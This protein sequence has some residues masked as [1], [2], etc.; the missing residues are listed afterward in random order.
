MFNGN[1]H[2]IKE[3]LELDHVTEVMINA[4]NQ[5]FIEHDGYLVQS[6]Q[7]FQSAQHYNEFIQ[8]VLKSYHSDNSGKL[9]YD[10][11]TPDGNRYNLVLPPV[12]ARGPILT[13]RRHSKAV[14]SMDQLVDVGFLSE[15][16]ALFLK[17]ALEARLNIVVCG[18]TS[19]GKTSFLNSLAL[20]IPHDQRVVSIEDT[21]E[22]KTNHPNW[23]HLLT[24]DRPELKYSARD[25]LKNTLRMR[26]DR[27]VVGE[28]RGPEA[29]DMLQAMNTG[30][31]GS[32][33]TLHASSP[34]EGLFRLE[35][36]ISLG[37]PE[38]PIA[39]IRSQ[40]A[41]AI[42]L[43]IQLKRN[44]NGQ[45]YVSDIIEITGKEQDVIT[46]AAVFT[47]NPNTQKLNVVGYVP[48]CLKKINRNGIIIPNQMFDTQT[49]I[50]KSS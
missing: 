9:N 14:Y 29:Y 13:I 7:H 48:N 39:F 4:W 12:A 43:V 24:V 41:A 27:I 26:P 15:K 21:L 10:G 18:G 23:V 49:V 11:V 42:S 5:V 22:L 50:K 6:S 31:E 40:M 19:T 16:A 34:G 33:T 47:F 3:L 28:C 38:V 45:R 44:E 2:F 20:S 8:S 37:H 36:L 25:C 30:H 17:A 46:R 1:A 32:M 35:N